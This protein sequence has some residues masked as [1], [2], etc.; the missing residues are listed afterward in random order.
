MAQI[1]VS[2]EREIAAPADAVYGILADYREHHPRILPPA[3]T[4][5]TVESGGISEGT[6]ILFDVRS[7][8]RTQSFHQRISEPEPG[9][10]L[11]ESAIDG[12]LATTFTVTPTG[13]ARCH[14]RIE[15]TW[16]SGGARGWLERLLAPR[17][18]RP[19]YRDELDRLDRYARTQGNVG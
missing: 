17:L 1:S 8:G 14:V 3:F 12:D 10:V 7:G 11:R 15:T 19:I 4:G 16:T 9:R 2:A 6:V 5:F 13:D 18:L